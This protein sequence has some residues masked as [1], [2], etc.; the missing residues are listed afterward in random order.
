[1]IGHVVLVNVPLGWFAV[2]QASGEVTVVSA[3]GRQLPGLDDTVESDFRSDSWEALTNHTT[4]DTLT[5]RIIGTGTGRAH[6]AALMQRGRV[7]LAGAPVRSLRFDSRYATRG[8][9]AK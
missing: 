8:P 4:G 3:T 6:A 1:V 5:V 2:E 7:G 9:G